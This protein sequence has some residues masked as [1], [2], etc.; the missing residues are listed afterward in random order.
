MFNKSVVFVI[1]AGASHEFEMPL[2]GALKTAIAKKLKFRFEHNVQVDGDEVLMN[3][4]RRHVPELVRQN[5]Y[6]VAANTLANAAKSFISIDEALHFVGSSAEAVEIGKI[7]IIQEILAA[8]AKSKVRYK[9]ENG[10]VNIDGCDQTWIAEVLSMA[11]A[12]QKQEELATAFRHVTFINFNY[13][14]VIEQYLYFALQERLAASP[15]AARHIVGNLHMI[16]PY[17][18]IAKFAYQM[19]DPRSFGSTAYFDPFKTIGNLRTY[20]ESDPLHD[21]S[22]VANAL[23]NAALVIFLG[24]GYHATN[25]DILRAR[26]DTFNKA[27]V[28]GTLVGIHPGN[29]TVIGNRIAANL[30]I[31]GGL[32]DLEPNMGAAELLQ[33]LRQ[34]ILIALE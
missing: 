12:G 24:F 27:R 17:G 21:A 10:R 25:L 1:G 11:V 29:T 13:D 19:G 4:I 3:H 14:R 32:V 18:S 22:D 30:H 16:R 28:L 2:G 6:T 26:Q 15:E 20:T 8:E 34:R 33:R 31:D 7:A 5:A 9:P 23:S